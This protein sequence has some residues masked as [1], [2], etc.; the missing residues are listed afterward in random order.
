[1]DE[2]DLDHTEAVRVIATIL[3]DAYLRLR[4]P[5]LSTSEVD[6]AENTR[7]HVTGS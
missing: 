1:M 3:A 6:C 4:L 2:E 5:K 7:P